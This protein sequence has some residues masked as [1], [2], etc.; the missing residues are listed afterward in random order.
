M[1]LKQFFVLA[2]ALLAATASFAQ[3]N[4]CER[5][6][7]A[8]AWNIQWLGNP[9]AG[10]RKAQAPEDIA[11]YIQAA[12]VSII[13]LSEISATAKTADGGRNATLDAAFNIAN[14]GNGADWRYVLF[15]K[16]Q[17]STLPDD[18]W[19][20]VAWN[21]KV[22]R[23]V[24]GPWPLAASVDPAK[25]NS[26]KSRIPDADGTLVLN[27][28]PHAMKFSAGAGLTDFVVVPVHMKSNRLDRK[29]SAEVKAAAQQA[30][31]ETRAYETELLV[32]GLKAMRQQL[33]DDDVI[34]LGDTNIHVAS[35][36]AVRVLT[37]AGFKDCNSRDFGTHI[38]GGRAPF[39]RIYLRADQPETAPSCPPRGNGSSPLDF[40][41]VRPADWRQGT[42]DST[43]RKLLSD[44]MLVRVG[45]CVTKDDD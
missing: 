11:D 40:K 7:Q 26:L 25:E 14:K 23:R 30:L 44:H 18:Q 4:T 24:A 21:E 37:T 28:W 3:G 10:G 8:G 2:A 34:V 32:A 36:P 6:I 16:R 42:T 13:A 27:R 15:P 38:G 35:E 20:G 9:T 31:V 41:R 29:H 1:V 12:E 33:Q 17:G 39:D 5:V 19:T 43:F 22:V 45:F